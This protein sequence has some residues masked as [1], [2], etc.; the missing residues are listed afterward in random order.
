MAAIDK[1]KIVAHDTPYNL[2]KQ[3]TSTVMKMETSDVETLSNRLSEK[4]LKYKTSGNLVTTYVNNP[5]QI[6]GILSDNKQIINDLEVTK[7]S[8]NDV[9]LAI[10]GKEIRE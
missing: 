10:T 4:K 7:G 2:K 6:L 1:G 3:Y 5:D 9:F 8:L